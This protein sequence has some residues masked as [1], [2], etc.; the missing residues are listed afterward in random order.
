MVS[1]TTKRR[2]AG[3]VRVRKMCAIALMSAV[4]AVCAW[5]TIPLPAISFT[6]QIFGV[7]AALTILG[8]CDGTIAIAVYLMLG[9]AGVP[10]FSGFRG[11]VG[12]LT[13]ATG[14]Y[15]VGFL[16]MGLL[17][18]LLEKRGGNG[19]VRRMV[20][21]LAGLAVCYAFGT[22]W[23]AV[24]FA[25]GRS[26][27]AILSLCVFPFIVPDVLKIVLACVVGVAIRRSGVMNALSEEVS[28]TVTRDGERRQ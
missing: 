17:Y 3:R 22:A 2:S 21:L 23:F 24:M 6:M 1:V 16:L 4:I 7:A 26:V 13:N 18:R 19:A 12:V 25:G 10:V 5:I 8:G 20:S 11:G 27:W 15:I 9:L 14:G 28:D